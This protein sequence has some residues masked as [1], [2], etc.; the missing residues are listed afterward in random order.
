MLDARYWIPDPYRSE[1]QLRIEGIQNPV[2]SICFKF[3][4]QPQ[5]AGNGK[6]GLLI[7]VP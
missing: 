1:E 5:N 4:K 6:A 2:S 3:G 7:F